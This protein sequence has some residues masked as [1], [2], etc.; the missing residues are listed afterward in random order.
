M[1][2]LDPLE[3]FKKPDHFAPHDRQNDFIE[4]PDT[5]FEALYGGALGGGKTFCLIYL[6]VARRFHE[7]YAFRGI[8]FRR[9]F[10]ELEKYIIPEARKIYEPLGAV[11][12]EGKHYFKFPSGARIFLSHMEQEKDVLTHDT[13]E[14]H[15]VAIDQAEKFTEFQL[16][17]ISSR[18]RTSNKQLPTIYRMSANPGGISHKYL[19]NRFIKPAREGYTILYDPLTKSKRIFI[20][21]KIEDNPSLGEADPNYINRLNLLPEKERKAKING[22]WFALGGAVFSEF[23]EKKL[24]NEPENA[25]HVIPPFEIPEWWPK[26]IGIDWGFTA[27]T[28]ALWC[29]ISPDDRLFIYREYYQN[30]TTIANWSSDVS[31]LSQFDGNI[32]KVVLDPSAW[33]NRGEE[34]TIAEQFKK[35]S[36]FIPLKADNDRLGGKQLIHDF[37]RFIPKSHRYLPAEGYSQDRHDRILRNYGLEAA[38]DYQKLFAP[39]PPETNLP[40]LQIFNSCTNIIEQLQVAQYDEDHPEDVMKKGWEDDAYDACRY[41]LKS[42]DHYLREVSKENEYRHTRG[43]IEKVRETDMHSYYMRMEY[44]EQKKMAPSTKPVKLYH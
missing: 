36:K 34:L 9:T 20:P 38:R 17:Y 39:E 26:I 41:V 37:L 22:D 30:K 12:N 5:I 13:N 28:C 2:D 6:P 10:A 24:P 44:L 1:S 19:L 25:L 29:A 3:E 7:H 33:Q 42:S 31:R 18:I 16:R 21:A 14:Y 11:Y 8:I 15:Y 23:R 4:L 27:H 40:R 35:W 32:K 43:E